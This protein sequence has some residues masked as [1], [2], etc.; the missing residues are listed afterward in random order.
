MKRKRRELTA[1]AT[2]DEALRVLYPAFTALGERITMGADLATRARWLR[3]SKRPFVYIAG[4]MLSTG[5]PYA[6]VRAGVEAGHRAIEL[7][8][9]PFIPQTHALVDMVCPTLSYDQWLDVDYRWLSICHA[10]CFLPGSEDSAGARE[11]A[12]F[13]A[14]FGRDM[15]V[16]RDVNDLPPPS[17]YWATHGGVQ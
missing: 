11:E 6:N 8:W 5:N 17:D 4:P 10:V 15:V 2:E 9:A 14:I 3:A 13:Q 16:V 12:N 1:L 7:G